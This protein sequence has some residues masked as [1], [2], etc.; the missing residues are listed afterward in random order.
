MRDPYVERAID[1]VVLPPIK[2]QVQRFTGLDLTR[3]RSE[4]V[5]QI[6]LVARQRDLL[7]VQLH[8]A[9][10][11]VDREPTELQLPLLHARR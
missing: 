9:G 2:L 8:G 5:Q 6:E 11:R 10:R 7:S 3:P 1:A 4:E